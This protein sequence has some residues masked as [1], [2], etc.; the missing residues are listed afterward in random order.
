MPKGILVSSCLIG[1]NC[2][3]DGGAR[4]D[5][6]VFGLCERFDCV[7]TC[8]ELEGGLGCPREIHEISGGNGDDVLEGRARV[9]SFSGADRTGNF[10]EGAESALK[11]ALE[12][13]ISVAIMKSKSPSCGKYKIYS[14]KFDKT[15]RDGCGVTTALL[16][17]NGIKV[18]TEKEIKAVREELR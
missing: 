16:C 4:T 13:Q 2:S 5:I 12:N 9:M 6:K 18:F 1:K 8:P 3:Y 11:K 14:G 15:L 10:I 7:D 17:R